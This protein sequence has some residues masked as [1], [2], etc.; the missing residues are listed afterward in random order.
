MV[1]LELEDDTEAS[2]TTYVQ[3]EL[4]RSGYILAQR[5]GLN[6]LRIDP[7]L[8]IESKDIESFLEIFENL[9]TVK[10]PGPAS[11]P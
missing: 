3:K 9:L 10:N 7:S 2:Y 4:L 11:D 6:V 1:A 8:T 5:P